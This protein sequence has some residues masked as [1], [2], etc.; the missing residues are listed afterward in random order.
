MSKGNLT[1]PEGILLLCT[2]VIL[3]GTGLIFLC[4]SPLGIDDYGILDIIGAIIIG[5]WLYLR[6]GKTAG[7]KVLQKF[8]IAFGIEAVPFIGSISPSWTILVWDQLKS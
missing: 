4:F 2:A 3:D 7:T 8:L 1:G 6:K 5:G